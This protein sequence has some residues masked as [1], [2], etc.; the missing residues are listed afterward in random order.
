MGTL[1]DKLDHYDEV[2]KSYNSI[3]EVG[4]QNIKRDVKDFIEKLKKIKQQPSQEHFVAQIDK[5]A[6]EKLI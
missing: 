5:L 2:I 1:S 6:G 3:G 4:L